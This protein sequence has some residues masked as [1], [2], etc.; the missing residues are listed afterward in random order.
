MRRRSRNHG[1]NCERTSAE[2]CKSSFR[3][4]KLEQNKQNAFSTLPS[5]LKPQYYGTLDRDMIVSVFG[6]TLSIDEMI[7][8]LLFNAACMKDLC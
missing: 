2:T 8:I 7:S 5:R 1:A 4:W 6:M 3:N